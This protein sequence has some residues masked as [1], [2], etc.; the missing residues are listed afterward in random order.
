MRKRKERDMSQKVMDRKEVHAL[1]RCMNEYHEG[2]RDLP[3]EI[4]AKRKEI[5]RAVRNAQLFR[6]RTGAIDYSMLDE[7]NRL[8]RELDGVYG[9]WARDETR[10]IL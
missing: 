8:R 10:E 5:A 1:L 9:G 4:T 3:P 7:V 2:K 6:A